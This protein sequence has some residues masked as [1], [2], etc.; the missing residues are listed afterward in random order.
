[1][2]RKIIALPAVEHSVALSQG[3]LV[4]KILNLDVGVRRAVMVFNVGHRP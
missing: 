2:D 1:M 4:W 3:E